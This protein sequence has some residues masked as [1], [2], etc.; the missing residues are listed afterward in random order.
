VY[1][2]YLCSKGNVGFTVRDCAA[3]ALEAGVKLY[4]LIFYIPIE[5]PL[6][7]DGVRTTNEEFRKSIDQMMNTYITEA[8]INQGLNHI[9]K[10]EGTLEERILAIKTIV[11]ARLG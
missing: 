9:H 8:S 2:E 5:F 10:I 7:D 4:D 6:Q 11:N 3:N 1:T